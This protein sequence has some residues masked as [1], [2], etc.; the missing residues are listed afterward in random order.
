MMLVIMMELRALLLL[1][2]Q[3]PCV[4]YRVQVLQVHSDSAMSTQRGKVWVEGCKKKLITRQNENVLCLSL[5]P[6]YITE[7]RCLSQ[8]CVRSSYNFEGKD[9]T[10]L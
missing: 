8:Y 3:R 10:L 4:E 7:K 9:S 5:G 1:N 2:R 6:F